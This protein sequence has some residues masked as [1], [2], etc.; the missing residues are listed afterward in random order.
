[1]T[2]QKQLREEYEEM[3]INFRAEAEKLFGRRTKYQLDPIGYRNEDT[4]ETTM[5]LNDPLYGGITFKVWLNECVLTNLKECI[6][7]LS[8]EVVHL[9]SP[10][11]QSEGNEVN[12]LEEG[13]AV[14]LSKRITERECKDY[15]YCNAA[16]AKLPAYYQAYMRYMSL[17]EID[18]KAIAK[19][20]KYQTVIGSLQ[21]DDFLKAGIAVPKELADLLLEKFVRPGSEG[22]GDC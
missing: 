1:M 14:Y 11:E 12:Y 5:L 19:V 6:F 10:V 18:P 22:S 16:I 4:P 21:Y 3:L 15:N 2:D 20:R 9:L 8:H 7:Q 13:M 17:V